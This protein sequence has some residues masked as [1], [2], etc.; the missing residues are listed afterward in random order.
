VICCEYPFEEIVENDE[1]TMVSVF[2]H[3]VVVGESINDIFY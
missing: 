1:K 3:S 2:T